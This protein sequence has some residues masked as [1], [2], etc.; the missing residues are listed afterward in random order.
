MKNFY[1]SDNNSRK[2]NMKDVLQYR[3]ILE[4][5]R[6]G[7]GK[8]VWYLDI[9][10]R[11]VNNVF[12][13]RTVYN[14][15][16][17]KEIGLLVIL[18]NK[19]F[20]E[21]VYQDLMNGDM[22]DIAIITGNNEQIVSRNPE[23]TYLF[24]K[25]LQKLTNNGNGWTIDEKG[26]ALISYVSMIDPDWK[27]VTYISL[28]KLYKE[29]SI[30]RQRIII[31]CIISVLILSVLSL[32]IAVDFIKPINKLVKGME[33]VQKGQND[34]FIDVDRKDELGFLGNTFNKMVKEINHLVTWIYREQITRKDAE[35]K[36]LQSQINPHFLFNTLE[37]IN[38]MERLNNVP[39]ISETVTALSSLMEASI[40]RDDKLITIEEEFTY[41]D[42]YI[43]ILKRRFEDK[44]ELK[45]E[46]QEDIGQYKIPR[47][48]IQ[49]LIEN[50]V[51]HGIENIREKG[52]ISLKAYSNGEVLTIDVEDNGMGIEEDELLFIN[53]K[54]S[55]DNDTYFR[56]LDSKRSK[57]IG[58]ENVNRRIKLFYGEEYGLS[59]ESEKGN[60]TR[61]V[62]RIPL[63]NSN[64]EVLHVQGFDN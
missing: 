32:Y 22:Q 34:V 40:G 8:V 13:A 64:K 30:L 55:M 42:N 9:K 25:D 17:F 18:I 63:K 60:Y 38:W 56:T 11:K 41:I 19:E 12:L 44:I 16:N 43:L 58:I 52:I 28:D 31:L 24:D 39:E 6:L 14:Q 2:I 20:L 35:L 29:I 47:L 54:L 51:Y 21:T 15:D 59:I 7:Q 45:K 57:S 49:P 1:Y 62:V 5:A 4:K 61:V 10:D 26:G 27:V 33:K 23:N 53:E 48:L 50:A 36:A 46:V 3:N 37:S